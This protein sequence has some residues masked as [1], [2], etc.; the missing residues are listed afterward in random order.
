MKHTVYPSY[1]SE[2]RRRK[3]E[4]VSIKWVVAVAVPRE[5]KKSTFWF[6]R[7]LY[8]RVGICVRFFL[9]QI[10]TA[11]VSSSRQQSS[12]TK[13]ASK[14]WNKYYIYI[15]SWLD[16]FEQSPKYCKLLETKSHSYY[17]TVFK[18]YTISKNY[19]CETFDG[20][21]RYISYFKGNGVASNL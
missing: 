9:M 15:E 2:A 16:L 17:Q 18:L 5:E 21:L 14:Q 11:W 4:R 3:W 12:W 8:I 7:D 10:E 1:R 19:T 20:L 13:L 6:D